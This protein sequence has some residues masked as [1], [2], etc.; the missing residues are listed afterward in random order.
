[1]VNIADIAEYGWCQRKLRPLTAP[2]VP[3]HWCSFFPSWWMT[4]RTNR[5]VS[6]CFHCLAV[7]HLNLHCS[8]F[9]NRTD[10]GSVFQP[11][12]SGI[13]TVLSSYR[14]FHSHDQ[15][16]VLIPKTYPSQPKTVRKIGKFEIEKTNHWDHY[17]FWSQSQSGRSCLVA[18]CHDSAIT[19]TRTVVF[20]KHLLP[21][22]QLQSR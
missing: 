18:R 20:E 13:S 1:M 11:T 10:I 12:F 16:L 9:L 2:T 4:R 8:H 15:P 5:L 19:T 6:S 17:K 3:V 21:R 7:N 14:T 22:I